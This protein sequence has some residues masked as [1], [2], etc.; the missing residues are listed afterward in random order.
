MAHLTR[1]GFTLVELLVAIAIIA[2]LSAILLPNFMGARE[3]AKDAQKI[4]DMSAMKNALRMYYNDFQAYPTG[5]ETTLG[6]GF[7]GY[8]A[9]DIGFTYDYWQTNSGDGFELCF[10]LDA[11]Q[12]DDDV[13]SQLKC[14]A[15]TTGTCGLGVGVTVDKLFVVCAK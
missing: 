11:G 15:M 13:A 3:K 7:S 10:N 1:W 4:Q 9:T 5:T 12:G 8:M 2:T 6:T 14:G